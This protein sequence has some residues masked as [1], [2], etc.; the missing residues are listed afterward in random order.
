MLYFYR[1]DFILDDVALDDP[2]RAPIDD[3]GN[4]GKRRQNEGGGGQEQAH[5]MG[6]SALT[7]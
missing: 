4:T 2:P 7:S 5:H 6:M 1:G 3:Q